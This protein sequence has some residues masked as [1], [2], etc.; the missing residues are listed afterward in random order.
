[1]KKPIFLNLL[2]LFSNKVSMFIFSNSEID[3]KTAF[4]RLISAHFG[5]LC[6][7]PKGSGI[8]SSITP[9]FF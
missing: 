1:M 7:P 3:N 6:A 5:S 9:K 4:F 8:I 2:Y